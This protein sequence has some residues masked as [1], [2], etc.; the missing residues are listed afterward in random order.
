MFSWSAVTKC[1]LCPRRRSVR[2]SAVA[3]LLLIYVATVMGIPL[4]VGTTANR[5]NEQI[6]CAGG[7]C[8]CDSAASC[9]NSC[10]CHSLVERLNWARRH[11]V[12]PPEI[13]LAWAREQRLDVF[14]LDNSMAPSMRF[15]A[16]RRACSAA[17]RNNVAAAASLKVTTSLTCCDT[18]AARLKPASDAAADVDFVVA[19]RARTCQGKPVNWFPAIPQLLI[20]ETCVAD[21]APLVVW[22]GPLCSGR[23]RGISLQPNVPP[24]ERIEA[25]LLALS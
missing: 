21:D 18:A 20:P 14:W 13:A 16:I 25:I 19:L 15:L 4:P 23:A 8:G 12:R 6:P 24:P 10:C 5:T 1:R 22:L 3:S 11:G 7:G 9:W 2:K 17:Q